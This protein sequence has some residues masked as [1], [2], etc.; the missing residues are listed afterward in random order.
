M[1]RK[2]PENF[3]KRQLEEANHIATKQ[4]RALVDIAKLVKSSNEELRKMRRSFEAFS[5]AVLA[6]KMEPSQASTLTMA[7]YRPPSSDDEP[8]TASGYMTGL[9]VAVG[10]E[11]KTLREAMQGD[12]R[13]GYGDVVEDA[14]VVIGIDAALEDP[15]SLAL[16]APRSMQGNH[17]IIADEEQAREVLTRVEAAW[18]SRGGGAS[19][20]G[21][22]EGEFAA[23][24]QREALVQEV[25]DLLAKWQGSSEPISDS[26]AESR[27]ADALLEAIAEGEHPPTL[28]IP[29]EECIDVSRARGGYTGT[30]PGQLAGIVHQAESYGGETMTPGGVPEGQPYPRMEISNAGPSPMDYT[31]SHLSRQARA[32]RQQQNGGA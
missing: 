28:D 21:N 32:A 7:G 27:A 19:V 1:S 18:Q 6:M 10:E 13:F 24:M 12:A 5:E 15:A 26:P 29:E 25:R 2:E 23:G 11:G 4:H 8:G 30:V 20:D 9:P 17:V 16:V 22:A 14:R 3:Y 31:L